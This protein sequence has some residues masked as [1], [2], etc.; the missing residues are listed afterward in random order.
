MFNLT[1][2]KEKNRRKEMFN[3][4]DAKEKNRRKRDVQLD[5]C[6]REDISPMS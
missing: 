1:D 4:T 2:A 5:R 3:L 6:Q